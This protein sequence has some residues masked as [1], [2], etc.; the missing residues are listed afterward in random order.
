M[1]AAF[2]SGEAELCF[3]ESDETTKI[4]LGRD[5]NERLIERSSVLGYDYYINVD[6][7]HE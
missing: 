2:V 7:R 1:K 3:T 5:F 4:V 6:A